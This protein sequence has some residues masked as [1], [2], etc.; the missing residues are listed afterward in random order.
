MIYRR[1]NE[2]TIPSLRS[3]SAV[4][5]FGSDAADSLESLRASRT[6]K[7][8]PRPY[9]DSNRGHV[10]NREYSTQILRPGVGVTHI[11]RKGTDA[12]SSS[13]RRG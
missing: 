9:L 5:R 4:A 2:L 12:I 8:L 7:S 10:K 11:L 13:R 6:M 3:V 1:Q